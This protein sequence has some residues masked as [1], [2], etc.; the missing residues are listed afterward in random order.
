[1]VVAWYA[2]LSFTLTMFVV[3]EG[4]DIGAGMLQYVVGKTEAERRIVV[5]AIGPLWSWHEVWLVAFGGTLL[6]AFPSIMAV[7][8]SGFYLA[9]FLLLWCLI[10]RGVSIEVSGHIEDP[11]WRTAWHFCFVIS[12]VLLAILVG[13]ALGNVIRGVPV[14]VRGTFALAFF[15]NFSPRGDVGILDWYTVSLAVFSLVTMAAHGANGL[16]QRT[17]GLVH[18]RSIQVAKRLWIIVLCLLAVIVVETR[19]VRP[20]LLS[21]MFHQPFGY[22]GLLCLAAGVVSIFA[23]LD[24]GQESLSLIGSNLFIAG[25]M[26]TGAAGIFPTILRSTIAPEYSL[27]AYQTAADGNGLV[28]GLAWWPVALLFALGYFWFTYRNYSGKVKPTEDTQRP[29]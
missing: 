13:A 4:F 28:I 1:M 5:A 3:L 21:Q 22:I 15:T 24:R 6:L 11:L 18:D 7:S 17:N 23:G 2:I 10:L 27:S 9:F 14:D 8:F 16:A 12:N 19:R 20:E 25:L 26:I 29:Y